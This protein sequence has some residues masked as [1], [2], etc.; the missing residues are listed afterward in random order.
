MKIKIS[1]TFVGKCDLC[2]R[3][4]KV[5]KIGDEESKKAVTICED[6][7]KSYGNESLEFMIEKFGKEDK[8]AFESGVKELKGAGS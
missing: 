8:E 1:A 7:A 4:A 3:T 5:F 6:C 2:G